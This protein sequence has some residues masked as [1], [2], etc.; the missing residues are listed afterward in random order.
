MKLTFPFLVGIT[1]CCSL[2]RVLQFTNAAL[3]QEPVCI[4]NAYQHSKESSADFNMA[5]DVLLQRFTFPIYMS[6]C[7][8][9]RCILRK[10][11]ACCYLK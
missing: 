10:L 4:N 7:V 11:E 8:C 1:V 6:V 2:Q 9:E 3:G 5:G